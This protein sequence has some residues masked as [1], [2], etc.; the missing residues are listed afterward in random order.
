VSV[1]PATLSLNQG[2]TGQLT[3]TLRDAAGTV[4]TGRTV[5]WTTSAA[6]V[7]T[8]NGSGLVTGQGVGS[9]TITA[10]SEGQNGSADVTVTVS[11]G[12]ET[13]DILNNASFETGW[14]GFVD[15]TFS[16]SPAGV[17]RSTDHAYNG[18]YGLKWV[19]ASGR[20]YGS[21]TFYDIGSNR[22][23]FWVRVWFYAA[24][25]PNGAGF[26]LFRLQSAGGEY[27]R[28][29]QW[30]NGELCWITSNAGV[31]YFHATP[32]LNTWH[33]VEYEYDQSNHVIRVWYDGQPQTWSI[34]LTGGV[35]S[36]SG[37]DL[38]DSSGDP[39]ARYLDLIRVINVATNSGSFYV[40]RVAVSTRGRIGP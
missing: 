38:H 19:W 15:G 9:A 22:T 10:T 34:Y 3:A 16:S 6:G 4:L 25:W 32:T 8:V 23:H 31:A 17:S 29:I 30:L 28:G 14:D 1:S 39:V 35:L 26:K 37:Y 7:A 24:A 33:S 36:A 21:Q 40:D 2:Q 12:F 5:T 13:P 27:Q 20:E 11:S 18:S